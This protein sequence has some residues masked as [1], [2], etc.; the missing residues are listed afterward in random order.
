MVAKGKKQMT[1]KKSFR[2]ATLPGDGIGPEVTRPTIQILELVQEVTG[3][4]ELN[5]EMLDAGAA[6]YQRD[7]N[8]FT[9]DDFEACSRA[10]AILLGAMGMPNIRYPDGTEI[11]PQ[12][13]LRV[14]LNLYAGVRPVR[15]FP[16]LPLPL[17]D[18]RAKQLDY[19]LLRESTEGLFSARGKCQMDGDLAAHDT[20]TITRSASERLFN[21][22]F[23]LAIR[24]R[25]KGF[26]GRVTCVDKS[27]V[28]GSFAF[29]R[30]IFDERARLYPD[31]EVEYCY[32]DAMALRLVQQPWIFDVVVTENMFGDI[33]SDVG[34]GLMGGMGFAPSADIGD[35]HAVFQ[36]CHG[37]APDIYGKGIA[38]PIATMLSASLMLEW[39]SDKYSNRHCSLAA[40]LID[41]AIDASFAS[42]TL[43]PVELGG[44]AGTDEITQAVVSNIKER[45]VHPIP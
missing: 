21:F 38:N 35:D 22:A 39:I 44:S 29:F 20:M 8:A 12:L 3:G 27:N 14:R 32:I 5:F 30:R 43:V 19:V 25:E 23:N 13:D 41:S 26:R 9:E 1:S 16:A 36:P 10:D 17:S 18:V 37:S 2:I 42:G 34:A 4:F 24:R 45:S 31:I 33:L 40:K 15:T 11:A 7:G 6:R 28:I